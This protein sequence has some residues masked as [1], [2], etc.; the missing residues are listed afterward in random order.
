M[1][2]LKPQGYHAMLVCV[3]RQLLAAFLFWKP[4][5]AFRQEEFKLIPDQGSLG[6]VSEG[7]AVFR[8]RDLPSIFGE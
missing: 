2:P 5:G 6:P 8:N 4:S 3:H 7:H 1:L